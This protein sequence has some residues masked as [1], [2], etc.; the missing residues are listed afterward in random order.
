MLGKVLY[1]S[2]IYIDVN[3]S[4]RQSDLEIPLLQDL[5]RIAIL[6]SHHRLFVPERGVSVDP[7]AGVSAG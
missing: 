6:D 7:T 1:Y 5:R 3:L 2:V 4:Y